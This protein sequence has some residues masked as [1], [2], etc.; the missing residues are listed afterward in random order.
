MNR[1]MLLAMVLFGFASLVS[2]QTNLITL[3]ELD[4]A[5]GDWPNSVTATT[6]I[7][8]SIKF[9]QAVITKGEV[10][11]VLSVSNV[12]MSILYRGLTNEI[13]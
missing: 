7:S 12:S 5:K 3:S 11:S 9:G 10:L 4:S 6:N 1:T 8:V 13:L 2:A